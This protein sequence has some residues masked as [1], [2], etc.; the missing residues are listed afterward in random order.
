MDS[1][2]DKGYKNVYK[3]FS[4]MTKYNDGGPDDERFKRYV[5]SSSRI[6]AE[7][8]SGEVHVI[9]GERAGERVV[10]RDLGDEAALGG[11]RIQ[12]NIRGIS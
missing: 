8:A 11:R 6:F 1:F 9:L 4:T 5:D 2:V 12:R 3:A 7:H 10:E